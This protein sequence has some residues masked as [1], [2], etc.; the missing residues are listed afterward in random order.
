MKSDYNS[1]PADIVCCIGPAIS[2]CC[3]EIDESCYKHFAD[4]PELDLEKIMTPKENGKYM[5]DLLEANRQ[6]LLQ[7]GI[8]AENITVSDVCTKCNSNLLWSHRATNGH[9]GTMSA[10]M[11][12]NESNK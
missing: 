3:Y 6:I 10:F 12:I 4:I 7:S 11:C 2:K 9:R 5:A 8:K 1:S